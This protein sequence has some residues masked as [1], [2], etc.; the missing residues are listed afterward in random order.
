[1]EAVLWNRKHDAGEGIEEVQDWKVAHMN[2]F[3]DVNWKPDMESP[4][5]LQEDFAVYFS[6][7]LTVDP[8][9]SPEEVKQCFTQ[10]RGPIVLM[11]NVWECSGSGSAMLEE[12]PD[13]KQSVEQ[14]YKFVDGDDW[15]AFFMFANNKT[16]VLYFWDLA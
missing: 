2:L 16:H 5:D 9:S 4:P 11:I 13:D 1:M 14:V 7:P 10:A 15:Q 8:I 3:N 6:I 12:E